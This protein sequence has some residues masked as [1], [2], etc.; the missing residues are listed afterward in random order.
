MASDPKISHRTPLQ[1]CH[2][3]GIPLPDETILTFD[4][5][6]LGKLELRHKGDYLEVHRTGGTSLTRLTIEPVVSNEIW[7]RLEAPPG[8]TPA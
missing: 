3:D 2:E 1:W 5:G 6:R 7:L 4:L 8:E